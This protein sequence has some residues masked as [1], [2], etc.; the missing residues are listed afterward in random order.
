[1]GASYQE[2]DDSKLMEKVAGTL[3]QGS[4]VGWFQGSMEFG[5]RALG[6]RSI[7]A[8]P[9]DGKARDLINS[10][11]K[12]RESFRPFAP[13]VMEEH[14][15]DYFEL[16]RPSPYMQ[17]VA[18]VR[19]ERRSQIPAVT[20]IDGSARIQTVN[21]THNPRFYRLLKEFQKQTGCPLLLNTSFNVRGEPIVESPR[22]AYQCLMRTG[23]DCIVLENFF[24]EKK[25]QPANPEYT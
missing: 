23:L 15:A 14:S 12:F 1:M 25:D 6:N 5:P 20:H 11:I 10:R 3:A 19:P 7:L 18:P 21:S 9:R 4:I 17:L 22:Q 16:D 24:L 13:A 2:L 8:D